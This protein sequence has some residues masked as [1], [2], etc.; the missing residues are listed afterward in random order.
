MSAAVNDRPHDLIVPVPHLPLTG[1]LH[2]LRREFARWLATG[3]MITITLAVVVCATLYFWPRPAPPGY[4]D[5]PRV[6]VGR[7][8]PQPPPIP[9]PGLPGP[10]YVVTPDVGKVS[11]EPTDEPVVVDDPRLHAEEPREGSDGSV[12]GPAPNEPITSITTGEVPPVT[13]P[14][15]EDYAWFDTEPVLMS[16]DPP[17]YPAMVR[18]AGIDG[19]VLVRVFIALNGHVKDAA[20]VE[21]SSALREAALTCARTAIFKPALQGTHPVE[22]WVVIPITF[23]LHQR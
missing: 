6:D 7:I 23:Q 16:I 13:P 5:M 18:D 10:A 11:Y 9:D 22:V 2:P 14:Q 17:V 1:E 12:D 4:I 21:G 15:G 19:T 20:V 3:N 8:F